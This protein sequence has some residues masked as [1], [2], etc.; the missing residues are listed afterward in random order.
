MRKGFWEVFEAVAP[1]RVVSRMTVELDGLVLR[2]DAPVRCDRPVD[3]F[4]LQPMVDHDLEVRWEGDLLSVVGYYVKVTLDDD[5]RDRQP[6]R[7][8]G[9]LY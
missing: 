9:S 1:G 6:P 4:H 2:P 7:D 3:G 8:S 5:T